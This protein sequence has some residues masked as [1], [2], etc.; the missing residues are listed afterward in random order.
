MSD[1][2]HEG[3]VYMV[4]YVFLYHA[5]NRK[6]SMVVWYLHSFIKILI[7]NIL[8]CDKWGSPDELDAADY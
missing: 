1:L 6:T 7:D 5:K 8:L 3:Y 2:Y 4:T